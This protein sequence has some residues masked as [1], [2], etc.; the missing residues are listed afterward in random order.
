MKFLLTKTIRTR[1]EFYS[2]RYWTKEKKND[3]KTNR[4]T[5]RKTT[6]NFDTL[7][8]TRPKAVNLQTK[9]T[10]M[11]KRLF[12]ESPLEFLK[13]IHSHYKNIS[14]VTISILLLRK[15]SKQLNRSDY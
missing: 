9:K 15:L 8:P 13:D 10:Q 1:Q 2:A 12:S 4:R 11:S 14:K 3:P 7:G 6:E 5:R